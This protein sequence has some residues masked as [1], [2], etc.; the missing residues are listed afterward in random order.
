MSL[1]SVR[2]LRLGYLFLGV[3]DEQGPICL[4]E[5]NEIEKA[6]LST[7]GFLGYR[8]PVGELQTAAVIEHKRYGHLS[9]LV[10]V[11]RREDPTGLG[12]ELH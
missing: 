3:R 7:P 6:V 5:I 2:V 12:Q 11:P 1:L 10:K 9:L 4:L 8:P